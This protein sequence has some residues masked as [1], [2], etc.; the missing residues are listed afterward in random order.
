[1]TKGIYYKINGVWT[2]ITRPYVKKKNAWVPVKETWVKRSG[3][4]QQCY[5]YDIVPPDAPLLSVQLVETKYGQGNKKVGRHLKVGVRLP[6]DDHDPELRLIRVLTTYKGK[7]P[8]TQFGGNYVANP[9]EEFPHEPWSDFKYT[10]KASDRNSSTYQYKKW[11]RNAGDSSTLPAGKQYFGAWSLDDDG[12]WS[13]ASIISID[14]PKVGEDT[15]NVVVKEARFSP[16]S[17]GTYKGGT[18]SAGNLTQANS[19]R[20]HGYYFYGTDILEAVGQ[21]GNVTI[22][23]AQIRLTRTNDNGDAKANVYAGWVDYGNSSGIAGGGTPTEIRLLGTLA[24]GQSKWFDLPAAWNG[25]YKNGIRGLAFWHQDPQKVRAGS[26]D[27]SVLQST[28][29][30]R[31]GEIHLVWEEAL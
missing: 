31:N 14:I 7:A 30:N 27:Y 19:P 3:T 18:F 17:G 11:P 25:N 21:Q 28:S 5:D 4:W 20:S 26:D 15:E 16:S 2:K 29:G 6:G 10:G 1:M 8:T 12:N 24:K 13:A 9:A 22:R 23:N